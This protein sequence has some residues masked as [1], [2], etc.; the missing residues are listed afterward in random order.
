MKSPTF[1]NCLIVEV[2]KALREV[3]KTKL[4]IG[5]KFDKGVKEKYVEKL[6]D[7]LFFFKI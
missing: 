3:R 1:R 2:E 7:F 5:R 6:L 4:L